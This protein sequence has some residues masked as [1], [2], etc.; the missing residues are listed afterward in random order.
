MKLLYYFVLCKRTKRSI[1]IIIKKRR[2]YLY[3]W[4]ESIYLPKY[5]V[6]CIKKKFSNKTGYLYFGSKALLSCLLS[7]LNENIINVQKGLL[8]LA[9]YIIS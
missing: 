9:D 6:C 2:I 5:Y 3:I 1:L 8:Q 4:M 7:C